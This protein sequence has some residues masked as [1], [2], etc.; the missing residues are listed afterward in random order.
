MASFTPLQPLN[1][2]TSKLQFLYRGDNGLVAGV[3]YPVWVLHRDRIRGRLVDIEG[4]LSF[5]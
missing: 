4:K 1:T 5:T 3:K 2:L